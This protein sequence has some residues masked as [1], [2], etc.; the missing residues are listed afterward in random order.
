ML[1][2]TFVQVV[3]TMGSAL[4]RTILWDC[5]ITRDCS[6]AY[7]IGAGSVP[8]GFSSSFAE[9]LAHSVLVDRVV[10]CLFIIYICV[11]V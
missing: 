4:E 9:W 11:H 3:S 6:V 10:D 5:V 8:F 1:V 7:P 2:L